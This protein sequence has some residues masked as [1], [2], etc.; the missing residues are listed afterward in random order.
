M[1]TLSL[2]HTHTHTHWHAHS[3]TGTDTR[4]HARTQVLRDSGAQLIIADVEFA[5]ALKAAIEHGSRTGPL[6]IHTIMWTQLA[7]AP[8]HDFTAPGVES[9]VTPADG[10]PQPPPGVRATMY[11]GGLAVVCV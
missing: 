4:I 8:P 6:P 3:L 11:H 9:E 2:T 5:S 10:H 1:I 7:H